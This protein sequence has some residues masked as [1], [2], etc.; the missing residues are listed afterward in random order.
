MKGKITKQFNLWCIGK[1]G[2]KVM[3]YVSYRGY[4]MT[5]CAK[6]ELL[7]TLIESFNYDYELLENDFEFDN[8]IGEYNR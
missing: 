4:S 8:N 2:M 1:Y 6:E 7:D 3:D 5:E